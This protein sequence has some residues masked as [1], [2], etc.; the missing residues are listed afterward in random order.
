[1]SFAPKYTFLAWCPDYTEEGTLQRRLAVR[2][3]HLA[4]LQTNIEQGVFKFGGFT[5][6]A[7]S[8]G[9]DPADVKING[10]NMIF[11]AESV[12]E[13]RKII[14]ADPYWAHN[15]WD[16]ER[17]DIRPIVVSPLTPLK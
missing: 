17:V 8:V 15:V 3:Q 6:T 13:V 9:A 7:D 10:S 4:K 14:E 16:K 1:M 5:T 12:E 2:P 11:Y